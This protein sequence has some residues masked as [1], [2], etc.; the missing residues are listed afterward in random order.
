[1]YIC[2]SKSSNLSLLT[3]LSLV[4]ICLFCM[5]VPLF[6]LCKLVHLYQ[7][8][9]FHIYVLIFNIFI[10]TNI[11]GLS[12][13]LHKAISVASVCK[14]DYGRW[15]G[16][17]Q[18]DPQG[19]IEEAQVRENDGLE[20][21]RSSQ[22]SNKGQAAALLSNSV[23]IQFLSSGSTI[24]WSDC[25]FLNPLPA[26]THLW[27]EMLHVKQ[28]LLSR[29][30][31]RLLLLHPWCLSHGDS[32]STSSIHFHK[33][34]PLPLSQTECG[35]V[36]GS[37]WRRVDQFSMVTAT[38]Y[39]SQGKYW[40]VEKLFCFFLVPLAFMNQHKQKPKQVLIFIHLDPSG[41]PQW[42]RW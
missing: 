35:D 7:F 42:L 2:Q 16:K 27:P 19:A 12:E 22:T 32:T 21:I 13:L 37:P 33:F 41:L 6:L 28:Q 9:R 15:Q 17:V 23:C 4:S 26:S 25:F 3:G 38:S 5:S 30:A 36:L 40:T 29:V 8:S 39:L 34:H 11:Q 31:L 24:L 14:I 18:G 10:S 20:L 1:M